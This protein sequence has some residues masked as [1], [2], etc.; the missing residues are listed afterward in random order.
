[1]PTGMDSYFGPKLNWTEP[2]P[3][4]GSLDWDFNQ[5][6]FKAGGSVVNPTVDAQQMLEID[7]RID[8]GDLTRGHFRDIG[9]GRYTDLIE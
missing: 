6:G 8:D 2:T 4:G 1:M 7:R 3:I 9:A 5:F